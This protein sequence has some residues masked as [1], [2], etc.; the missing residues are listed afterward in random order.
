MSIGTGL[1]SY[2]YNFTMTSAT[3][4][5]ARIVFDLGTSTTGISIT[6]LKV[7]ELSFV[8]TSV[9]ESIAQKT[10]A[11]PNPVVNKLYSDILP[12]FSKAVVYD[13]RG[14]ALAEYNLSPSTEFLDM[15]SVPEGYYI[16]RL[17]GAPGQVH[18]RIV[19]R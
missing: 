3:D 17:S 7:D 11:Y 19:K 4:P 10:Y 15:S 6:D 13:T 18:L 16:V 8:V 14:S 5:A 12:R 9:E 1:S 2:T